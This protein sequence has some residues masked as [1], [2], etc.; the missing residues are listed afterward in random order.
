MGLSRSKP[1]LEIK[2]GGVDSIDSSQ[3]EDIQSQMKNCI[4]KIIVE[5]EKKNFGT[6][7]FCKIPFP[8]TLNPLPVLIT[9]NHVLDKDSIAEGKKIKFTLNN[10]EIKKSIVINKSRKVYTRTKEE[11]RKDITIIEIDPQKD[12]I[13]LD[14]FL[15]VDENIFK[16]N[17]KNKYKNKSV[18]AIHY[19]NGKT[20]KLSP[21]SISLIADNKISFNHN[22][23][24]EE[25]SSG[26]PI[27]NLQNYGVIG[28]HWGALD[29]INK[30]TLL[31]IPI[32]EFNELYKK[33]EPID[34]DQELPDKEEAKPVK[35]NDSFSTN[36]SNPLSLN[37]QKNQPTKI[38]CPSYQTKTEAG[39][40]YVSNIELLKIN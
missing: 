37:N 28:V 25:G 29:Q 27:I 14:S 33:K 31:K 35:T 5:K 36:L 3:M 16:D 34:K 2:R 19:E 7:F 1:K 24:T 23:S 15:N 30:G 32:D 21:G 18:Y 40:F 8:D 12:N 38:K 10:D 26:C 6:G 17:L 11:E 13:N 9:C 20:K 22:C 39:N 4:C